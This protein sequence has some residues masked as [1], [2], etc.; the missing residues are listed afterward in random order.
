MSRCCTR[1]GSPQ[2][3]EPI[4]FA[5]Q[6]APILQQRCV[7]CH[8][9]GN[10]KGDV[11]LATIADVK[12]QEYV[13]PGD[14]E[15]SG[16]FDLITAA[17][18]ESP[19]MP[20]EGE[21]LS[22]EQVAL[23][24]QWIEEGADWPENVVVRVKSRADTSWWSL[25]PLAINPPPSPADL[26]EDWRVNPID[27]FVF[28][29]MAEDDLSPNPPA[30]RRTL[31]RRTTYDLIGLPP[32][33]EEVA[34]FVADPDPQ[35]YERLIDRLLASPHYGERWGRHWLDV[36]RFGESNGYERNVI[37][38][39]L[40]PFRDYVIASLN[41]DKPFDQFLRE[42]LSGDV[43][44]AGVPEHEIGT[45]FLVAG[46]YDDV[47]NQ[48]AAQAAQIRANTIDE[49]IRATS[50][51]FL[52]LTIGCARCHDHKFDPILQQRLLRMV[53]DVLGSTSRQSGRRHGTATD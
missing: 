11:S 53:C 19:A 34:D 30:D 1:H 13:V 49:M 40:W 8:A 21:P 26:P 4:D 35:A 41:Q 25:L 7:T 23:I 17:D 36:V 39:D 31:I 45:A 2:A 48:D 50:E 37:I 47:G 38:N 6:I 15:A 5:T 14:P 16:L 51:A 27:R 43:F 9:P 33:P 29:R 3:D 42:H 10:E 24:R 44:G 32:T 18:G 52:G 28:A 22:A 12:D 20:R 46:P